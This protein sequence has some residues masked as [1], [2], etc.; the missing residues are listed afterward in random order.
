MFNTPRKIRISSSLSDRFAVDHHQ[1][2]LG[3]DIYNNLKVDKSYSTFIVE[4]TQCFMI[5][6]FFS[7]T[8]KSERR[9]SSSL[10][11][12]VSSSLARTSQRKKLS[13]LRRPIMGE[14]IKIRRLLFYH[15]TGVPKI[16]I[17]RQ[18]FSKN[19][20]YS[21]SRKSVQWESTPYF[22]T[23]KQT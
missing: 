16:G 12:T 19:S 17:C 18:M 4:N 6:G 1:D 14:I 10:T 21:F 5:N 11:K 22:R 20:R 23:D 7:L 3:G 2:V 9:K 13:R 8:R 15:T